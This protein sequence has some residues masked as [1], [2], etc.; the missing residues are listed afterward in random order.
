MYNVNGGATFYGPVYYFIPSIANGASGLTD[1]EVI[2][3]ATTMASQDAACPVAAV[4]NMSGHPINQVTNN[5][6]YPVTSTIASGTAALL[7]TPSGTTAIKTG[8]CATTISV[9]AAG[10]SSTD[11]IQADFNT[12]P[13][14]VAGFGGG[15]SG[16]LTI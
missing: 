1:D 6:A 12:P 15:S 10:V 13:L 4:C 3:F 7:N 5:V 11:N 2:E 8:S 9:A 16:L 14:S